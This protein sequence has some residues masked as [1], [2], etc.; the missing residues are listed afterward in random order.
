MTSGNCSVSFRLVAFLMAIPVISIAQTGSAVLEVMPETNNVQRS[1]FRNNSF[2]LKNTGSKN[3]IAFELDVTEALF[4]DA[5]FDPEGKAGDSVA[6]PLAINRNDQ[7]GVVHHR[8]PKA[9][10]YQGVGG[11]RGY[12]KLVITFDPGNENGFNPGE[13]LGFAIDMDPNSIAGTSKRPLDKGSS[14][15]WDVGGVSGAELIGSTFEVTFADG[16]KATGVLFATGTQ[17]GSHGLAT[18]QPSET[19]VE[20]VANGKRAGKTGTYSTGG[21]QIWVQ[22]DKGLHVR[23]VLAKGFIQPVSPYD[24]KLEDHLHTLSREPFPANNAVEFQFADL[25]L[26]GEP[27]D[28]SS[29]FEFDSI[30]AYDFQA[31]PDKPFSIDEDKVPLAII[32]AVIDPDNNNLPYGLV[33]AP[34][35]LTYEQ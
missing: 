18:E 33:T 2:L 25:T 32:A 9:P 30:D 14:P 21:P 24:E 17:A 6:K 26:T 35:Y 7:T 12:E 34:I 22:G 1:N 16:S 28:I 10:H 15:R 23:V 4:P 31:D 13:S 20:L 5:V 3:I 11:D 27:I 19:K 29:E 8:G